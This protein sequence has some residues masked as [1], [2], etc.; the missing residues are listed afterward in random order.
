MLTLLDPDSLASTCNSLVILSNDSLTA[1][2]RFSILLE[3]VCGVT[4]PTALVEGE[5]DS[6]ELVALGVSNMLECLLVSAAVSDVAVAASMLAATVEEAWAAYVE[7][8]VLRGLL[9]TSMAG[10]TLL[11]L[12]LNSVLK[13]LEQ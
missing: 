4:L 5:L 8:M 11:S 3:G 6:V 10:A 2:L 1:E 9:W 13:H 7:E 12:L